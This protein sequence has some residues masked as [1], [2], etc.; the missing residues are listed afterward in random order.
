MDVDKKRCQL[1]IYVQV[2][3]EVSKILSQH[4]C[5]QALHA[6]PYM[7]N[8]HKY[9]TGDNPVVAS[10]GC[11]TAGLG[12]AMPE[13]G[14]YGKDLNGGINILACIGNSLKLSF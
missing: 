13:M 11:G 9:L 10:A 12:I 2:N 14:T 1:A 8:S 3:T 7:L 5:L 6:K 4:V